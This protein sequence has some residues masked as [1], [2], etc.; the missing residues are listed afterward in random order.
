M[1]FRTSLAL[2][3]M[4]SL[5]TLTAS[6]QE[7]KGDPYTLDHCIVSGA[8]FDGTTSVVKVY[9]G[10]EVRFCGEGCSAKFEASKDE[11]L[12]KLDAE[13][14]AQQ[15]PNYPTAQCVSMP[16]EKIDE[17]LDFVYNNRLFRVCCEDCIDDIHKDPA[18]YTAELDKAVVAKQKDAYP[19]KTCVVSDEPL[20]GSHGEVIEYVAANRL[21]RLCCK[22]CIKA[23]DK[24]PAK[25]LAKIDA[26]KAAE[27]KS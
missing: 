26:A 19:L 15:K 20:D 5:A 22:G 23:F 10:R 8:K 27:P 4:A 3:L 7:R 16:E 13:I 6:A 21:V 24:D 9:D 25:F 1:L 11:Y 18:K 17:K 12:K 14:I 2:A